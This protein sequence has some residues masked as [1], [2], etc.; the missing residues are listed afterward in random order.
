VRYLLHHVLGA[1][2]D[3]WPE[4]PALVHGERVLSFA[5]LEAR[6]NQLARLLVQELGVR[7]SDRVGIHLDKSVE[8][9]VAVYAVLKTGGV[10]VPLD[11]RAPGPRIAYMARDCGMRCLLTDRGQAGQWA[12]LA[13][14]G[15][16]VQSLVVMDAAAG[17][18]QP[19]PAALRVCGSEAIEAQPAHDPAVPALSADLAYIL[20]TSGSTGSPKGVMLSHRNALAFVE[21]SAAAFGIGPDDR[22]SSHAPLHFDLSIFDLFAAALG[23]ARTVLVDAHL[24]MLPVEVARFI[25]RHAITIWYSVPSILS[26][27]ASRGGLV[28]GDL[29]HLRTVL[30]AGEVFPSK[31]LR[32]LMRLLPRARFYNL[33]GPTETNVCAYHNVA[34]PPE[35][36]EPV[37]IGGPVADVELYVVRPDGTVADVDEV[38]ELW[39]R[40]ASVMRGYWGDEERTSRSLVPNPWSVGA[41]DDVYRT[42]DFVSRDAGGTLRFM[43]RRDDQVKSRGYRIALGDVEAAVMAHPSVE[44]CAVVAVPDDTVTSR[45]FAFVVCRDG[46]TVADLRRFSAQR[47]PGYMLPEWFELRDGLP[48]TPTGKIDRRTLREA[49]IGARRAHG[50]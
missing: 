50:E 4:R 32:H 31:H 17:A 5:S 3:R 36:S 13:A 41:R 16:P 28:G 26:L 18:C 20:Y 30:F 35:E 40:G 11:S 7:R 23:G 12:R 39:V 42:G 24:A 1:A 47:L 9:V 19:A 21:W 27:L 2:A 22:L 15:L 48:K 49:A 44:E 25:A 29:P 34:A 38:G 46:L 14:E 37:P 45:L 33:F 43:G 8:S 10:Y 6:S